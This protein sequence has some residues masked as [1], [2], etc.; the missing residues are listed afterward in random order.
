MYHASIRHPDFNNMFT[1]SSVA[2]HDRIK[3]Q[4][5]GPYSGRE[6]TAMEPVCV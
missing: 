6:A 4:L 3:A 1:T 5:M 2:E